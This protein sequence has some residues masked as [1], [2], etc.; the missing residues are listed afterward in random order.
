MSHSRQAVIRGP[1]FTGAGK[2][3]ERTPAHHVDFDTG[4]GPFGPITSA[5]LRRRC[6]VGWFIGKPSLF[7]MARFRWGR[8][9][10]EDAAEVGASQL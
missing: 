9:P 3:P 4:I 2:R 6:V 10:V 7:L 5:S 8:R 1:S